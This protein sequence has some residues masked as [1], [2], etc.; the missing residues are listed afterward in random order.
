MKTTITEQNEKLIIGD[1]FMNNGFVTVTIK[2][3]DGEKEF[4]VSAT[5]LFYAVKP[6]KEKY[7]NSLK[8]DKLLE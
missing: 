5:D 3:K 6:F 2:D 8:R 4:D 1:D 7:F